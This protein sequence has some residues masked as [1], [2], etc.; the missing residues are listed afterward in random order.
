MRYLEYD[1]G[2]K[3]IEISVD[4]SEIEDCMYDA[5]TNLTKEQ[6]IDLFMDCVS[7]DEMFDI[8]F[9]DLY[10]RNESVARDLVDERY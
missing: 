9:E 5:L 10:E 8:V 1:F 4:N 3:Q 2:N 7:Y 6:I